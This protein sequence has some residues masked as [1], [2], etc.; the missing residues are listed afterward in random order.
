MFNGAAVVPVNL[1]SKSFSAGGND[2]IALRDLP[3]TLFGRI[4][5]LVGIVFNVSATPTFGVG[6]EPTTVGINNVVKKCDFW[7]GGM[8]RFQ[9]GF[10]HLRARERL[11]NGGIVN[12]DA[13]TATAS[14]VS[15]H[16]R[17]TW[18]PG[19][20]NYANQSDFA[21]PVG[22]LRDA[23]VRLEYGSLSDIG[24][25]VTA[26][27][28]TVRPVALLSLLD[29]VRVPPAYQFV[30]STLNAADQLI[31]GRALYTHLALLNSASFDA[32]TAGDFESVS[33]DMGFGNVLT[34]V[35][36]DALTALFQASFGRGSVDGV[37]GEPAAASD[38]N[39][40]GISETTLVA[41]SADL[42]PVLFNGPG[43]KLSK[44]F[45]AET[46]LRIQWSGSQTSAVALM[47]RILEQ[48]PAV[49]QR[50]TQLATDVL[51]RTPR[52]IEIKTASKKP[53]TGP[54]KGFMPWQVKV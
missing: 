5:H 1:P 3:A 7:D 29:E 14:T 41:Q 30:Q 35:R 2:T 18:T 16:F 20:A 53:Y 10:N 25:G 45:R 54:Q 40:K 28:A 50:I 23:E 31:P 32:I 24:A 36:T 17:R 13:D 51:K 22:S 33:V 48:P 27:T 38:D 39:M 8:N 26:L 21:I 42:Q 37:Q 46:G 4:C 49:V 15:R 11:E 9:G 34:G 52:S 47:G 44:A 19:P 6:G 43:A 12:P